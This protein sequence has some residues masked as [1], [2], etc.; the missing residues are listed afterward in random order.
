MKALLLLL[1]TMCVV[2]TASA[3]TYVRVEKDGTKTYSD[4]PIPGG[5]PVELEPAQT[6][7]S[8]ARPS[9]PAGSSSNAPAEQR[10]LQQMDDF[11]YTS[12]SLSPENEASF[13]NPPGVPISV[14][15]EPNLRP[16]DVVTLSV[17]GQVVGNTLTHTLQP[18]HRGAHTVQ[19]TVK[20][21]Y[22][23]ELCSATTTFH[24]FRPSLNMPRR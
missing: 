1:G 11:R 23:R 8:P 18:A 6:Y 9:A 21:N 20:D 5:Q 15:L 17:D 16:N 19:V 4:R 2:S 22:G 3:T 14:R 24:V 10:L 7:T 12:C 13:T